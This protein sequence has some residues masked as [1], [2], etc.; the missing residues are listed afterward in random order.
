MT[1][2]EDLILIVSRHTRHKPE[3]S[4]VERPRPALLSSVSDPRASSL[5]PLRDARVICSHGNFRLA[6][7]NNR[8]PCA[9]R[10]LR[11]QASRPVRCLKTWNAKTAPRTAFAS[12]FLASAG[13]L[14]TGGSASSEAGLAL[15]IAR[16]QFLRIPDVMAARSVLPSFVYKRASE[17]YFEQVRLIL[18]NLLFNR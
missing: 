16:I 18:T 5:R 10:V 11:G 13:A 3:L 12:V 2:S 9:H 8:M 1:T 6:L 14:G 4:K 7:Q 15:A 17:E